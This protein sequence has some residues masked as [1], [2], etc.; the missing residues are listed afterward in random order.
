MIF[1]LNGKEMLIL[2]QLETEISFDQWN[3]TDFKN[4]PEWANAEDKAKNLLNKGESLEDYENWSGFN[5][6]TDFYKPRNADSL[7]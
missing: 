6:I 7:A 4:T 1:K 5:L 2:S 3:S